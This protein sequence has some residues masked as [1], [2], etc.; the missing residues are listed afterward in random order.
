MNEVQLATCH[1]IISHPSKPKFMVVKHSTGWMPPTVRFPAAGFVGNRAQ[2]IAAGILNKYGLKVTVLR[3]LVETAN[4]HYIELEQQSGHNLKNLKSVWVGSKEYKEFRN[5]KAGQPDPL[6]DWL[7]DAEKGWVSPLR[8]A[9]ERKRWFKKAESWI[10]HELDRLHIQVTGSVQQKFVCW[11]AHT[12]L[13][14]NTA[15]GVVLFKASY[16]APPNEAAVTLAL[17]G[18]FPDLVPQ[19]LAS[20]VPNNWLLMDAY[21]ENGGLQTGDEDAFS[22]ARKFANFQLESSRHAVEWKKLEVPDRGIASLDLFLGEFDKLHPVLQSGENSLSAAELERLLPRIS[23]SQGLCRQLSEYALPATLVHPGFGATNVIREDGSLKVLNWSD[24]MVS[25]PFFS[26][27]V[28]LQSLGAQ[29]EQE[30]EL[31][32]AWFSAFAEFEPSSRLE[33]S[34]ELANRLLPAW[35]LY[36]WG[37]QMEYIEPDSVSHAAKTRVL[38]RLCREL[39]AAHESS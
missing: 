31:R 10:Q 30:K 14:V 7:R 15:R 18:R 4:R 19:P 27:S 22:I 26:A 34:F 9:W 28:F 25:H 29:G 6:A 1:C 3:H 17:A 5:R 11:P 32:N 39:I 2:M 36:R 37:A 16:P 33:E 35:Q 38:Q 23:D 21:H 20:D 24:V 13:Q 8:P 12:F